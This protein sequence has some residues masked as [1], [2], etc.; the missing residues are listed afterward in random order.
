MP[1]PQIPLGRFGKRAYGFMSIREPLVDDG[2]PHHD[3]VGHNTTLVAS[4]GGM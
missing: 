3:D 2:G 4:K 1:R